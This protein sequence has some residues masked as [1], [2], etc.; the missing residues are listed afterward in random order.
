MCSM[1]EWIIGHSVFP[2]RPMDFRSSYGLVLVEPEVCDWC[3][4]GNKAATGLEFSYL[5]PLTIWP[6][7]NDDFATDTVAAADSIA[8]RERNAI[9]TVLIVL[10]QADWTS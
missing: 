3:V 4:V 1:L 6:V 2:C 7:M 5:V 8:K 10:I 9:T